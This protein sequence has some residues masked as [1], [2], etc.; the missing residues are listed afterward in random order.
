[1]NYSQWSEDDKQ[2]FL[3]RELSS[4][5]PLL[6]KNWEPSLETQ[7]VLDTC[8]IIAEQSE[9]SISCYIIRWLEQPLM[10]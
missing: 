2:C 5:R 6:P 7:E 10:Y 1:M 9:G 3:I 4:R 8:K